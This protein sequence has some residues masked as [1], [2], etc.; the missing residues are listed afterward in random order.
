ML[1]DLKPVQ[2]QILFN[3]NSFRMV[4]DGWVESPALAGWQH[5]LLC[6]YRLSLQQAV[7]LMDFGRHKSEKGMDSCRNPRKSGKKG[8]RTFLIDTCQTRSLLA[9]RLATILMTYD[10]TKM[11]KLGWIGSMSLTCLLLY[12]GTSLPRPGW[13][14]CIPAAERVIQA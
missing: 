11:D 7:Y 12:T 14:T 10:F 1:L 9:C 13:Q 6:F 4:L 5:C 8:L 2:N 3:C